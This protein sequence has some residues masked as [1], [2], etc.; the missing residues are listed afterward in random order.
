MGCH[1]GFVN[2]WSEDRTFLASFIACSMFL[3]LFLFVIYIMTLL[4]AANYNL[5]PWR[6]NPKVHHRIH[7]SPPTAPILD[8]VNP[9]HTPQPI[10]LRSILIPSSHLRLGL[11]SCLFLRQRIIGWLMILKA[12]G[13]KRSWPNFKYSRSI[14]VEELRKAI[15]SLGHSNW[16]S[17]RV[18]NPRPPNTTQVY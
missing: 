11:S 18:F 6:Q 8:Q 10:S 15:K 5:T 7:N 14:C 16:S 17:G 4:V 3:C 9:L 12:Y 1:A 2:G 13:R